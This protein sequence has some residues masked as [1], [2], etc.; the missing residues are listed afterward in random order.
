MVQGELFIDEKNDLRNQSPSFF[1]SHRIS[2]SLDKVILLSIAFLVLFALT[3]S[4]GYERGKRTAEQRIQELT[5]HIETIPPVVPT[6]PDAV[7]QQSQETLGSAPEGPTTTLNESKS[8]PISEDKTSLATETAVSS[9]TLDAKAMLAGKEKLQTA[10]TGK[11]TIQVATAINKVLAN[12]E[13]QKLEKKGRASFFIQRG[14]Y[15]EVC[16]GSFD[17]VQSAKPLLNERKAVSIYSDAFVRPL[18]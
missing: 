8:I 12:K 10:P 3:F 17:T 15:Y 4:F 9:E 14:R 7:L 18:S 11:Y 16:V 1:S 2:F 6:P 5:S 13:I